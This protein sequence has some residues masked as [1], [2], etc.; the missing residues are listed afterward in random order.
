[1][2]RVGLIRTTE[3]APYPA[4]VNNAVD[5]I[6]LTQKVSATNHEAPEFLDSD[7]N[8]NNLYGVENMSLEETK[9]KLD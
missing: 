3:A 7:Y 2:L 6:L 9:E 1:M 5:E 4:I 8:T